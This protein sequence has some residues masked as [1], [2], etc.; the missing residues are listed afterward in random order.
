EESLQLPAGSLM[1]DPI[2]SSEGSDGWS[3]QIRL[4]LLRHLYARRTPVKRPIFAEMHGDCLIFAADMNQFAVHVIGLIY[5]T[6]LLHSSHYAE[7]AGSPVEVDIIHG[8]R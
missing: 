6:H 7:N 4:E 8:G 5:W 1:S 3:I 2:R